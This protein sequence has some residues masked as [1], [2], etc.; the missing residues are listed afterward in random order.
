MKFQQRL[1]TA[2]AV[3][4][5]AFASPGARALVS[6]E[7]GRDHIFIDGS[8]EMAYD[9]NI[10]A[11]AQS[12]GGMSYQGSL[13]TEFT[14]HAGW[15]GVNVKASISFANYLK[16]HSQDYVDPSLSAELTKQTGRTTGSL[17]LSMQKVN[18]ADVDVNT[19]DVSRVY[20]AGLN[21]QYPV[22]ERYTISGS[23]DVNHVDYQDKLL[24]TNITTYSG[25]LYLYYILTEQRDLFID[26][27]TRL[28][29]EANGQRELD[30]SFTTGVSGKVIGPFNG[31]LQAGYQIRTP[32]GGTDN[33]R[34]GDVNASGT[35]TWNVTRRVTLTADL[36][37]DF[38]TTANALSVE[39]T[40]AGLTLQ[41]S[42]TS[43]AVATLDGSVGEN[44]FIGTQ[45]LLA[46]NSTGRLDRFVSLGGF[47]SYAFNQHLKV[48]AGYSYY[49][50]W[51]NVKYAAFPRSQFN[52]TVSSHW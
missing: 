3:T 34:T 9:S 45:G 31:S 7:D 29:N 6:L 35:M 24:F 22:I 2:A 44:K 48:Q 51:S 41:D 37:R 27:R 43:K 36:L 38:S 11:H 46:P 23:F 50:S 13:A 49:R 1:L 19:R 21:F 26:Y 40:S 52:L 8:V 14:R 28:S 17:T 33:A 5:A 39:A 12:G 10:F 18:R 25:S 32:S 15:I 47:Y 20:D 16:Y 4:T 30:N 42:L